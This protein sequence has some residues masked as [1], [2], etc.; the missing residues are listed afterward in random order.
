MHREPKQRYRPQ[1]HIRSV[2]RKIVANTATRG[3]RVWSR[4]EVEKLCL[5]GWVGGGEV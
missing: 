5:L 1:S 3:W 4:I 2:M